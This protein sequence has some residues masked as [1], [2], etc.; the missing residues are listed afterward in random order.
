MSCHESYIRFIII[1]YQTTVHVSLSEALKSGKF[2]TYIIIYNSLGIKHYVDLYIYI[3]TYIYI[4]IF[5]Y[6]ETSK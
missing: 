6:G 1:T 3:Y 5:R 4:Y 2:M